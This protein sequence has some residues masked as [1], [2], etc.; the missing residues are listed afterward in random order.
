MGPEQAGPEEAAADGASG[1]ATTSSSATAKSQRDD[2][3]AAEAKAED[4][5]RAAKAPPGKAAA[6][7][8]E[9]AAG[10]AGDEDAEL[11][12][13]KLMMGNSPRRPQGFSSLD[14]MAYSAYA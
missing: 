7:A 3:L 6:W 1:S 2:F 10:A 4:S 8:A 9:P 13:L 14:G 12:E 5:A 11:A